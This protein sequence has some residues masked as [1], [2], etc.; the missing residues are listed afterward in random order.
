M[1]KKY[2]AIIVLFSVFIALQGCGTSES[3][4]RDRAVEV[5]SDSDTTNYQELADYLRRLPG[6]RVTGS[7]QNTTVQVRGTSSFSSD[8]RPLYVVDG[9]VRG[10]DYTEVNRFIDINEVKSV[11]LLTGSDASAYGMRGANGVIE[12]VMKR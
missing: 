10:T 8:T 2:F 4:S 6:V 12:I 1:S 5:D 7:G 11:R 9:Q 3:A